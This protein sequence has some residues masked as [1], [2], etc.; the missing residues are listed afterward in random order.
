[1]SEK[2]YTEPIAASEHMRKLYADSTS[3]A[4]AV[5]RVA[6]NL[7][8]SMQKSPER[9]AAMRED[10]RAEYAHMLGIDTCREVF[11]TGA[12]E[13]EL[14]EISNDDNETISR[15]KLKI[16]DGVYFTGLLLVPK[17]RQAKAPLA[18]MSHGGGGSP[19]LCC[20]LIGPNNYGGVVRML[21]NRGVVVFA[22]Q[23]LLW[24][25]VPKEPNPNIPAYTTPYNRQNTDNEMRQCGTS[26]AG[27]EVYEFTRALDWLL[28]L[29]F[30][31]SE[32]VGM[33]GASYGGFY[34]LYTMAYETRIK[35][36]W[37]VAFFNDRTRYCWRDMV[38]MDSSGQ[39]L[40]TELT[41]L[42]APRR[43]WIDV[44]TEDPV[45]DNST[46]AELFPQV[47]AFYD[48]A[49]ASGN[50][51]CNLWKGGHRFSTDDGAL[52][53]FLAGMGVIV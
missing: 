2:Y 27:F 19:Q 6:A 49:G 39:F 50:V 3:N 21:L 47:Q 12:P 41:G 52:E 43:L 11:G 4:V 48:A 10:F 16:C 33:L 15:V 53:S 40:D 31:D 14:T 36:G 5:L 24:S 51:R 22:P 37:S 8:R 38:W 32:R 28:T 30:V 34:T 13:A 29:D 20:D 25:Y 46:V 17:Q 23:L 45:F 42:I 1:M 9:M 44:G 7:R 26:I 35:S 18:L